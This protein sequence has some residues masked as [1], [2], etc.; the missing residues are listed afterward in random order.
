VVIF[1]AS[2]LSGKLLNQAHVVLELLEAARCTKSLMLFQISL[3]FLFPFLA[4][5]VGKRL[6]I[7]VGFVDKF[8]AQSWINVRVTTMHLMAWAFRGVPL[9]SSKSIQMEVLMWSSPLGKWAEPSCDELLILFPFVC[10]LFLFI[11]L[12]ELIVLYKLYGM[13]DFDH[14]SWSTSL[15]ANWH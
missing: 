9:R 1:R 2:I 11:A 13:K 10:S 5:P 12:I 3:L 6:C 8:S 7:S 15:R 4:L 14:C